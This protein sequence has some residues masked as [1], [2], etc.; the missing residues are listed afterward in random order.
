M[1]GAEGSLGNLVKA[2]SF[3]DAS[4]LDASEVGIIV[5]M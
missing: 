4:L 1:H 2:L 3:L 5:F